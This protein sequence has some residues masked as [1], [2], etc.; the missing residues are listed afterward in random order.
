MPIWVSADAP[1]AVPFP[2]MEGQARRCFL[3]RAYEQAE[4]ETIDEAG[5]GAKIVLAVVPGVGNLGVNPVELDDIHPDVG[6]EAGGDASAGAHAEGVPVDGELEVH[7][8]LGPSQEDLAVGNVTA[9]PAPGVAR[10]EE[11]VDD[12]DVLRGAID[13]VRVGDG[14]VRNCAP[15]GP[16]VDHDRGA[17]TVEGEA[18]AL[19]RRRIGVEVVVVEAHLGTG[20][21]TL[22]ESATESPASG[23]NCLGVESSGKS[24]QQ[25]EQNSFNNAHEFFSL[26]HDQGCAGC[27]LD[28]TFSPGDLDGICRG[29]EGEVS[30]CAP[31]H[32][33]DREQ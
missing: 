4:L 16:Q 31:G 13:M 28:R 17:A 7:I 29:V 24:N 3:A 26:L 23:R 8:L 30:T 21:L 6:T 12:G 14:D 9:I 33:S 22:S 5:S 1:A 25:N 19:S 18:A 27:V 2:P 10:T 15:S 32:S 11:I 20:D